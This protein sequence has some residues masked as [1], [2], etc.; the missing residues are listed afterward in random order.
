[1]KCSRCNHENS[2][3]WLKYW[4]HCEYCGLNL[5][6][7]PKDVKLQTDIKFAFDPP[8]SSDLLS[9]ELN[10]KEEVKEKGIK[11]IEIKKLKNDDSSA[12]LF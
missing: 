1:M 7:N 6:F 8:D 3:R 5:K 10:I 4:D 9:L 2:E 11:I 12:R